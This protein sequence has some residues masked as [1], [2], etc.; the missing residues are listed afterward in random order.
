M[1]KELKFF[2]NNKHDF[3]LYTD[4]R[5]FLEKPM[6][7]ETKGEIFDSRNIVDQYETC[8]WLLK[9]FFNYQNL[10]QHIDVNEFCDPNNSKLKTIQIPEIT[11]NNLKFTKL[12]NEN[13]K[14]ENVYKIY[15][16]SNYCIK[17]KNNSLKK[18][19]KVLHINILYH[20][21]LKVALETF[22]L[23]LDEKT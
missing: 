18:Y 16:S 9:E 10:I 2:K 19:Y 6:Y 14:L 21:I 12:Q 1:Q 23:Y 4:V 11:L 22:K 8:H 20:T 17:S 13:Q 7:V 15:V 3:I 5:L